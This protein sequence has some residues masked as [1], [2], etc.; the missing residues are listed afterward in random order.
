MAGERG[1]RRAGAPPCHLLTGT[2]PKL[3]SLLNTL[4]RVIAKVDETMLG[5]HPERAACPVGMTTW[6]HV[7]N[8]TPC[9]APHYKRSPKGVKS[10]PGFGRRLPARGHGSR[11]PLTAPR[12]HD[13]GA[14][15][16]PG[17]SPGGPGPPAPRARGTTHSAETG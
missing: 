2:V 6:K 4:P 16:Q 3:P 7:E 5:E 10:G 12:T 1:G 13:F 14:R 11:L 17:L 15:L 8:S 9:P